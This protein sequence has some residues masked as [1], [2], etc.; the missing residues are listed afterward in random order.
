MTSVV[1]ADPL[2]LPYP[3][4]GR[5]LPDT[6]SL[7]EYAPRP[8]RAQGS[9]AC[10]EYAAIGAI[11]TGRRARGPCPL[12]S[13]SYL[14]IRSSLALYGDLA[15]ENLPC[16]MAG[17]MY[18]EWGACEQHLHPDSLHGAMP[19]AAADADAA[20]R[21]G[22]ANYSCVTPFARALDPALWEEPIADGIPVLFGFSIYSSFMNTPD[23]GL[24]K[25]PSTGDAYVGGHAMFALGY[26]RSRQLLLC[27]NNWSGDWADGSFCWLPY[28]YVRRYGNAGN[29]AWAFP[30]D[31][32]AAPT[33]PFPPPT[34]TTMLIDSTSP[35]TNVH[36]S[37]SVVGDTINLVP[38]RQA[39]EERLV[40]GYANVCARITG[41]LNQRPV[42]RIP[43]QLDSQYYFP[44]R[45]GEYGY[46]SYDR[47]TWTEMGLPA[48]FSEDGYVRCQ[49]SE[50][51]AQDV[52]W[53]ARS[54]RV[55]V[56]QVQAWL[57]QQPMFR[58]VDG[59]SSFAADTMLAQVDELGRSI[60][61]QPLLAWT[62][63]APGSDQWIWISLKT[64]AG[65]D[66]A[67]T[68]AMRGWDWL[69]GSSPEAIALRTRFN[70]LGTLNNP[71][72]TEGGH[73][74]GSFQYVGPSAP[75]GG[76]GNDINR[77]C[78]ERPSLLDAVQAIQRVVEGQIPTGKLV[79]QIDWHTTVEIGHAGQMYPYQP[80][81]PQGTAYTAAIRQRI[82]YCMPDLWA[83]PTGCV[84]RYAAD[85]GARAAVLLEV[86]QGWNN[87]RCTDQQAIDMG[88]GVMLAIA[89]VF[90]A[91]TP[92]PPLPLDEFDLLIAAIIQLENTIMALPTQEQAIAL[93]TKADELKVIG[94]NILAALPATPPPPPPPAPPP[95][96]T[97]T[98]SN[99]T[100]DHP[101]AHALDGSQLRYW[102]AK[103]STLPQW[104]EV[105]FGETRPLAGVVVYSLQDNWSTPLELVP[106]DLVFTQWGT[107]GFVV[108][109]GGAVQATIAGNNRVK[110]AIT[111]AAPIA[112][113]R[114]RI[115][116]T[117]GAPADG[118]ARI[119]E[120]RPVFAS[121]G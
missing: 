88:A 106:D 6:V 41:A 33:I 117:A 27:Q 53:F 64:H 94:Q 108:E 21:K 19:S 61:S 111:F 96:L 24:V 38:R 93:I 59:R 2:A 72:G 43:L 66:W 80:L 63:R 104:I 107:P 12:L 11:E 10:E 103:G 75:P 71:I 54:R 81:G 58:P 79:L 113:D 29:G 102:S 91:A 55:G 7:R 28:E 37:S 119:C 49:H 34:T 20:A 89:D 114:V 110:R 73:Y 22:A 25:M 69:C 42:F 70:F 118:W 47:L 101:P 121:T 83:L 45:P 51:F 17:R 78:A 16:L 50:P 60:H 86:N 14:P 90:G 1:V 39:N 46:F 67:A 62:L 77:H 115:T 31:L 5:T 100:S 112:C 105:A 4:S 13:A 18:R 76:L 97:A 87:P 36:P 30:P 68:C 116:V 120:V 40:P 32:P 95:T 98:A 82:A 57:A 3:R 85:L 35:Q 56:A 9:G 92:P 84:T 23:D 99:A 44:W 74:R 52:V 48:D 8:C 109:A 15:H 26:N 65:E